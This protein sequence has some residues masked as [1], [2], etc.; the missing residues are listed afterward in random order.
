MKMLGPTDFTT[1][2]V[3]DP[4]K[5]AILAQQVLAHAASVEIGCAFLALG[6]I[7]LLDVLVEAEVIDGER[8]AATMEQYKKAVE[9]K[10][11][12]GDKRDVFEIVFEEAGFKP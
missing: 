6:L 10:V 1:N 8:F 11:A 4:R 12:A 9:A 2:G 5:I 7:S 3:V